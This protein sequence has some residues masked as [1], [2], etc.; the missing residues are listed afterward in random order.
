VLYHLV[1]SWL[2]PQ[3]NTRINVINNLA[4]DPNLYTILLGW[5][6]ME[7]QSVYMND[8]NIEDRSN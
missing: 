7:N 3:F 8:Q 4:R 2:D 1:D 5:Y 6:T